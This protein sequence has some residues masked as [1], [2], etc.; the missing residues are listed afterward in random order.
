MEG[1]T[2]G[3]IYASWCINQTASK[4]LASRA[5]SIGREDSPS[6]PTTYRTIYLPSGLP[7]IRC[8]D[9]S[10]LQILGQVRD[11]ATWL[12]HSHRRPGMGL[13]HACMGTSTDGAAACLFSCRSLNKYPSAL[14]SWGWVVG[15]VVVA[16]CANGRSASLLAH[17]P[18]HLPASRALLCRCIYEHAT[19]STYQ[20]TC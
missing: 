8:A 9:M 18:T 5:T 13:R 14:W 4:N 3:W 10:T 20:S 2:C 15:V 16:A 7:L 17:S 6:A 12:S 19:H 11:L 1:W